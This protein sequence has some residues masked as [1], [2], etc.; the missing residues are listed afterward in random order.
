MA[1]AGGGG[2]AAAGASIRGTLSERGGKP[3]LDTPRGGVIFLTGD[4]PTLGVLTDKRLAGSD[5]EAL[6]QFRSETL[7]EIGPIHTRSMFVHR[8]G[9][10][11]YITYWCDLCSIR[12]YTPGICWCCQ[13]ETALDLREKDGS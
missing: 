6:G 3:A 1:L 11:L 7:F 2:L 10:R 5:F 9:K 8:G 4:Q 12:T 13:Q